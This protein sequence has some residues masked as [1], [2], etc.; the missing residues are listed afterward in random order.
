[1]ST[2]MFSWLLQVSTETTEN[3]TL[4]LLWVACAEAR[5]TVGD[6]SIDMVQIYWWFLAVV[7]KSW[8][9]K[10][11][12]FKLQGKTWNRWYRQNPFYDFMITTHASNLIRVLFLF[13][14]WLTVDSTLLLWFNKW[15][16]FQL[17]VCGKVCSGNLRNSNRPAS[18]LHTIPT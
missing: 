9:I 3:Q 7:H 18:K 5:T 8:E 11:L 14:H 4:F 6:W 17:V 12:R 10:S 13:L 16:G 15:T 1:M 2:E